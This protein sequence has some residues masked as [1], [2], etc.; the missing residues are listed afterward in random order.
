[1][2]LGHDVPRRRCPAG[3]LLLGKFTTAHR[4]AR[5]RRNLHKKKGCRQPFFDVRLKPL[6]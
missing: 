1:L 6:N 4:F 3:L 2:C 5:E